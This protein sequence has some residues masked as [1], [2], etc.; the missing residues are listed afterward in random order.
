MSLKLP[1]ELRA[2]ISKIQNHVESDL[3]FRPT[4][5]QTLHMLVKF[6]QIPEKDKANIVPFPKPDSIA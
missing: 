4:I 5:I 1:I 2:G 3:G 6:W